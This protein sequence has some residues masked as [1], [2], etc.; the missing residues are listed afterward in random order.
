MHRLQS[1]RINF[2]FAVCS[3]HQCRLRLHSLSSDT[4]LFLVYRS[5]LA[6]SIRDTSTLQRRDSIN[7]TST[8]SS[9]SC[10]SDSTQRRHSMSL[11]TIYIVNSLFRSRQVA[12]V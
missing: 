7:R 6:Q 12:S 10:R 8:A 9:T 5:S 2:S 3:I 1:T 11:L 4:A